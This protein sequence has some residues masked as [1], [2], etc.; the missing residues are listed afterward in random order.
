MVLGVICACVLAGTIG[1]AWLLSGRDKPPPAED[2]AVSGD[3]DLPGIEAAD[4][5]RVR[6]QIV[7]TT[8]AIVR[9]HL[10]RGKLARFM[11]NARLGPAFK[12]LLLVSGHV[13][14][15]TASGT[16]ELCLYEAYIRFV[17]ADG[18]VQLW[19]LD[20]NGRA[21]YL[22]DEAR[23]FRELGGNK[24]AGTPAEEQQWSQAIQTVEAAVERTLGGLVHTEGQ[25]RNRR[26][27]C[28][29]LK[30][31]WAVAGTAFTSD[32]TGHPFAAEVSRETGKVVKYSIDD[33]EYGMPET[34][35]E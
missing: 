19:M 26:P 24:F 31:T 9:S 25:G 32:G 5:K 3:V 18:D 2:G 14:T 23:A 1:T 29:R 8:Q 10:E 22:S 4:L 30:N 20:L 6:R 33:K 15:E 7:A 12:G 11:P 21:L 17:P 35:D 16:R 28:L 34:A 13:Q 27:W